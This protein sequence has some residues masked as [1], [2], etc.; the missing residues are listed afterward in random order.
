MKVRL[1]IKE[2]ELKEFKWKQ[3]FEINIMEKII[4][5]Y[6]IWAITDRYNIFLYS[7]MT[8]AYQTFFYFVKNARGFL[9][10]LNVFK[11]VPRK[12]MF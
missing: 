3:A 5:Y 1:I 11:E 10:L 6:Y 7:Y 12:L 8:N 2:E 9:V 4:D